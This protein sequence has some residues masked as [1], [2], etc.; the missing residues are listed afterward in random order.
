MKKI[1]K[2]TIKV[3]SN[4]ITKSNG[5]LDLTRISAL[6]DQ[7]AELHKNGIEVI[8]VS[9]G[10]VAA[11]RSTLKAKKKM[12]VVDERQLF[13][14]IGQA[15]LM[16]YYWDFFREHNIV[17]G[18][19]LTTKDNFSNRRGY[20]NQRNCIRVM[21][22][23]QV[24]PIVNENDA[25]SV[26]ELMFTDNDE[27]S[28]L[29]ASMM[30]SDA[31][32]ILTNVDGVFT[33]IPTDENSKLIRTIKK[34]Q[35]ISDYIQN[36]K[37]QFGRGGML[38]KEKI[39]RKMVDEGI[40]VFIANGKTDD[41]ISKVVNQENTLCT[42]FE[43]VTDEISSV[44]KWIAHSDGFAKGEI[45]INDNA[46]KALFGSKAVSVLPVGITMI[47]GNFEKDD[48]IKIYNESNRYL[49]IGKASYNSEKALDVIG[50]KN[51][52]PLIH[53]DYLFLE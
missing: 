44:K 4:V 12:D 38:T 50:K 53:C 20:L 46:E 32:L 36:T 35:S 37:S 19:V 10:A 43:S 52:K 29:V 6:V 14:A 31:L 41:I 13:S 5:K 21:L 18:Q 30:D 25:V 26:T 34:G 1:N 11:G 39:A 7:I 28:G 27:L 23:H 17:V 2:I 40:E 9:S 3:G 47:I 22:D 8:L 16:N 33:G 51:Q 24:I 45:I 49:G 48:L 42:H 15:K